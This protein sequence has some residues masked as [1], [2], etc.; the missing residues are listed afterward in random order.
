MITKSCKLFKLVSWS[1]IGIK[2]LYDILNFMNFIDEL[3]LLLGENEKNILSRMFKFY[4]INVVWSL[5]NEWVFIL[6][7]ENN[8]H[9]NDN[10]HSSHPHQRLTFENIYK[11]SSI[12][13]LLLLNLI[14]FFGHTLWN[15]KNNDQI[16]NTH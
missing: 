14:I 5:K 8:S 1:S 4:G 15:N 13:L 10:H 2:N 11:R 12:R 9:I 16:S 3:M 7:Q 6:E